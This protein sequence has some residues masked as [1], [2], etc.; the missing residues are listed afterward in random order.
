MERLPRDEPAATSD[1]SS[2]IVDVTLIPEIPTPATIPRLPQTT[3]KMEG[4]VRA[5]TVG[6]ESERC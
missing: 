5:C 6:K 4:L 2:A 3:G 1:S